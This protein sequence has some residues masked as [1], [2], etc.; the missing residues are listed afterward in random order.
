MSE[1]K[2]AQIEVRLDDEQFEFQLNQK[3]DVILDAAIDAGA[4]APFSCKGG[5]CT[6]CKAKLI[7]GTVSMDANF[8]LTDGEI[9]EGYILTCQSHPTS[10]KV[11]LSY[12]E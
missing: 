12:D 9:A 4:D 6:T 7:E 8:A 11:V 3:G 10:E 2:N 5:I 1:I